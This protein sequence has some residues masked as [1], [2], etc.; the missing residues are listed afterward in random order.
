MGDAPQTP[1][2]PHLIGFLAARDVPCPACGYNLRGLTTDRCPECDRELVLQIRLAE[3]RMA[4]W[5]TAV[6]G[7]AAMTGF[8]GLFLTLAVVVRLFLRR[9]QYLE[10]GMLVW[11]TVCALAGGVLL[12]WLISARRRFGNLAGHVRL[13]IAVVALIAATLSAVLLPFVFR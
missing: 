8:H 9:S 10:T 7:S 6:V 1:A 3:P 4:A 2:D 13:L 12:Y 5:I 11:L